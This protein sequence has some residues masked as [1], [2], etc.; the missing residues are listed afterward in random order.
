M[1]PEKLSAF[2]ERLL[3]AFADVPKGKIAEVMQVKASAISNYLYGRIPDA[4]KL[5]RI[6]EFTNCSIHWLITGEGEKLV[7]SD[8]PIN[9][10]ETFREV[11][12]EIVSAELDS[13][14]VARIPAQNVK[15]EKEKEKNNS[16]SPKK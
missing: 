12:R 9:L 4:D 13:R 3:E 2:G 14:N 1:K 6:S 8:K 15:N 10:D 11:V 7:N 16:P 5:K